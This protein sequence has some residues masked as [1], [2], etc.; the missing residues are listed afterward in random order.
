MR[1]S[2]HV[3]GNPA[4]TLRLVRGHAYTKRHKIQGP[5]L[6]YTIPTVRWTHTD[7]Y[8]CSGT[9]TGLNNTQTE[10]IRLNSKCCCSDHC[11]PFLLWDGHVPVSIRTTV[12]KGDVSYKH[13]L[14]SAIPVMDHNYFGNY[15]L[16]YNGQ[17]ITRFTIISEG[18][19]CLPI[20]IDW[21][22]N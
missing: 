21:V 10:W 3:D 8:R 9:S 18:Y 19:I 11:L 7:T 20:K 22:Y 2:C 5:L 13:V 16:S 6:N 4:P 12:P 15:T 17:T 14:E 1:I